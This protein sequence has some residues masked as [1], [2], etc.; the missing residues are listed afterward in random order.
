MRIRKSFLRTSTAIVALPL[1]L[2]APLSAQL[3]WSA[4][5]GPDRDGDWDTTATN[6][7]PAPGV[8][9]GSVAWTNGPT[10]AVFNNV[11][12]GLVTVTAPITAGGI[13]AGLGGTYTI[14]G[15]TITAAGPNLNVNVG[16]ANPLNIGS[17]LDA[18]TVVKLGPGTLNLTGTT[19][20]GL[21][22][23]GGL[24]TLS[25]D[26]I[27][28]GGTLDVQ[29][30]STVQL[31][32]NDT[33]NN[34]IIE[35]TLSG[36]GI[37]TAG[38]YS[39]NN[40]AVIDG[41]L[42]EGVFDKA[43]LGTVTING[44]AASDVVDVP[45]GTLILSGD[46][47]EDTAALSTMGLGIVQVN[48]TE[49][50]GTYSQAGSGGLNGAGILTAASGATLSGGDVNGNLMG[51]V[52]TTGPVTITV[53]GSVGGGFLAVDAGTLTLD[54]IATSTP[55]TIAGG[56]TLEDNSGGLDGAAMVT[57]EGTLNVNILGDTVDTYVSN[58][59]TLGGSF[60]ITT[61]GA[62][63]NDGSSVTGVLWG[64]TQT[65]GTVG[66]TGVLDVGTLTVNNGTLSVTG[67]GSILWDTS[68]NDGSLNLNAGPASFSGSMLTVGDG[69]GGPATARAESFAPAQLGGGT[70]VTVNS[71]GKLVALDDSIASLDVF[72]GVVDTG[73]G[74]FGLS[75]FG[76]VSL[77]GATIEG[78][79]PFVVAGGLVTVS[80][81]ATSTTISAP[82]DL[83][84]PTTFDVANGAAGDDLVI[85]GAVSG[86][87]SLDF[88]G[89]GTLV[90]SNP[91]NTYSGGTSI[92]GGTLTIGASGATGFGPITVFGSTINY[93]NGVNEVNPVNL[94]A[95]VD[96]NVDA[97]ASATQTGPINGAFGIT[98]IG[99]G[100]LDLAGANTF[101][102]PTNVDAGTLSLSGSLTSTMLGISMGAT[103]DNQSGGLAAGTDVTN[104]GTLN[105]G[106][107]NAVQHL[108]QQRWFAERS[109]N[110]DGDRRSDAERRIDGDRQ[111]FRQHDHQ[112]HGVNQ[113]D[114]GRRHARR[115]WCADHDQRRI[116]LPHHQRQ[117]R[118]A[119]PDRHGI[120][121]DRHLGQRGCRDNLRQHRY[122]R[123]QLR[124]RWGG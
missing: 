97:L 78:I 87:G 93:A 86:G 98:K 27:A 104:A 89:A 46:N 45:A 44:T 25:G 3:N 29:T 2:A 62:T 120:D 109:C 112:R 19:T 81:S 43:D 5:A 110:L 113:R 66:L 4:A 15:G 71:D 32:G 39:L 12:D 7:D 70:A 35:G 68:V 37:L 10:T 33:V 76:P 31:D 100:S 83:A 34:L 59:G 95:D 106:T 49:T 84:A 57:N 91:G 72:G 22:T 56:A 23:Q 9:A 38:T 58:G 53:S 14:T 96:L 107:N 82:V 69:I 123:H 67:G 75:V 50:V 102:G 92:N 108:R 117:Q 74:V 6:W 122:Q 88:V 55:V 63:L 18:G 60:L 26:N 40:G 73:L 54:G 116:Q 115:E 42:G 24:V 11:E 8:P 124:L 1:L 80:P 20:G 52:T 101:T 79:G 90:L 99:D 13:A 64:N 48:G 85:S 51:D 30:G 118:P 65:N 36:T 16:N 17:T 121:L 28:D 21:M 47:L 41:H 94:L 114:G 111:T 119:Q 105:V 77:E 103:F 61:G